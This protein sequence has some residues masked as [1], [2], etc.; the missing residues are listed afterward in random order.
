M[1]SSRTKLTPRTVQ[2]TKQLSDGTVRHIS[3]FITK[4]KR[5]SCDTEDWERT[6]TQKSMLKKVFDK[7]TWTENETLRVLQDRIVLG[8]NIWSLILTIILTVIFTALPKGNFY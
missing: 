7:T 2:V 1:G 5:G 6:Y 3:P 4:N 8:A